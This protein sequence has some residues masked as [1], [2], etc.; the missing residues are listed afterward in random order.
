MSATSD[1]TTTLQSQVDAG[2]GPSEYSSKPAALT[3]THQR[4][5][6]AFETTE[7]SHSYASRKHESTGT[8]KAW[9]RSTSFRSSL[10]GRQSSTPLRAKESPNSYPKQSSNLAAPCQPDLDMNISPS[11]PTFVPII[12]FSSPR[13]PLVPQAER[14]RPNIH[15]S[16]SHDSYHTVQGSQPDGAMSLVDSDI[17]PS[18]LLAFEMLTGEE[19]SSAEQKPYLRGGGGVEV[20]PS[21]QVN[22]TTTQC[23]ATPPP[24]F[25]SLP[26]CNIT[27]GLCRTDNTISDYSQTGFPSVTDQPQEEISD[28]SP[29]SKTAV[30]S[31]PALSSALNF[32]TIT[33]DLF[34]EIPGANVLRAINREARLIDGQFCNPRV[35]KRLSSQPLELH[36]RG[37]MQVDDKPSSIHL[38]W[39]SSKPKRESRSSLFR[40]VRGVFR[41]ET[42]L[43]QLPLS[44]KMEGDD[45]LQ[46]INTPILP[47]RVNRVPPSGVKKQRPGYA[48]AIDGAAD[49][50]PSPSR[51][52]SPDVNK[53]LPLSPG[54][55]ARVLSDRRHLRRASTASHDHPTPSPL[56]SGLHRSSSNRE[57][58]DR[59]RYT[60]SHQRLSARCFSPFGRRGPRHVRTR[61]EPINSSPVPFSY[62]TQPLSP[63]R[64]LV[65]TKTQDP[66]P[67]RPLHTRI[68]SPRTRLLCHLFDIPHR[69]SRELAHTRLP[70]NPRLL[71]HD[72]QTSSIVPHPIA[73]VPC[74]TIHLAQTRQSHQCQHDAQ[75]LSIVLYTT[76]PVPPTAIHQVQAWKSHQCQIPLSGQSRHSSAA[77]RARANAPRHPLLGLFSQFS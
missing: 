10:F 52:L 66:Y 16:E 20:A 71:R 12:Q 50:M 47:V 43:D 62:A 31:S 56:V 8:T 38:S 9:S 57:S 45:Q 3:F 77:A 61:T 24:A 28:A 13:L 37:S 25:L 64:A 60:L 27:T 34:E 4:L 53:A 23:S 73:L 21:N 46:S 1:K 22:K 26:G 2:E 44:V 65:L 6:T 72:A 49:E 18:V 74:T 67:T 69:C 30:T 29:R 70:P 51:S 48:L 41:K 58:G 36:D 14:V 68:R 40:G 54:E 39:T 32:P 75:T 63:L 55:L 59:S 15:T 76:A 42:L 5:R 19:S 33:R 7:G 11:L 35:W 17:D